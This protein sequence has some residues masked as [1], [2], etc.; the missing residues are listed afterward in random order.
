VTYPTVYC[1]DCGR[2]LTPCPARFDGEPT[3]V[4]FYPCQCNEARI[5]DVE[6][7]EWK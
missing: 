1:K 5:E 2:K 3:Y 7:E 4:G 6:R